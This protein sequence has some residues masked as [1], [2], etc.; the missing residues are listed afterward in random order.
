[1]SEISSL[2]CSADAKA[3]GPGALTGLN[4]DYRSEVIAT[5]P[6]YGLAAFWF[7]LFDRSHLVY[8]VTDRDRIPTLVAPREESLRLIAER[9]KWLFEHFV[10]CRP[11][12]QTWQRFVCT[13]TGVFFKV[14]ATNLYYASMDG[15]FEG[16]FV[17]AV[18]W[19][20]S[21]APEDFSE[22]LMLT[23]LVFDPVDP[24][25]CFDGEDHV[26]EEQLCGYF[27]VG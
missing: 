13:Q 20:E 11:F 1:M 23:R 10:G 12:W 25:I 4:Y 5:G 3:P 19:M 21:R 24:R 26:E 8:H 17:A 15:Y 2:L 22:L 14:D 6:N 7:T 9:E 18:R 16:Q 27:G